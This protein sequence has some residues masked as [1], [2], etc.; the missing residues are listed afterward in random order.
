MDPGSIPGISTIG[1]HHVLCEALRV[2]CLWRS[3]R[4][5]RATATSRARPHAKWQQRPIRA[6]GW[7]LLCPRR[8]AGCLRACARRQ[9]WPTRA[10]RFQVVSATP[11]ISSFIMSAGFR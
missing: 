5:R 9:L 2:A 3:W 7:G 10:R 8:D 6:R 4:F 11:L 1:R